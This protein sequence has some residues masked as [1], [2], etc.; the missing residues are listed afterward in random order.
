MIARMLLRNPQFIIMDEATSALDVETERLIS[1]AVNALLPESTK[2][3]ISH[4]FETIRECDKIIVLNNHEV[5]AI[6]TCDQ[7]MRNSTSF[8]MLFGRESP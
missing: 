2:I 4:R 7:L 6:G 5:E 8:K 1:D 3:I